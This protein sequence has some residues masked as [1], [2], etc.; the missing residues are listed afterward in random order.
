MRTTLKN[1][2]LRLFGT[3]T[4]TDKKF[5]W[6]QGKAAIGKLGSARFHNRDVF[7]LDENQFVNF[8]LEKE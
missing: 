5:C 7:K 1:R 6:P 3:F 4:S 2:N 8:K